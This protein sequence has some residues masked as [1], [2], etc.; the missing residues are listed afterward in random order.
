VSARAPQRSPA[1]GRR[2]WACW[3]CSPDATADL[4]CARRGPRRLGQPPTAPGSDFI[5]LK[6]GKLTRARNRPQV[7]GHKPTVVQLPARGRRSN[8]LEVLRRT[9]WPST[10]CGLSTGRS[11]CRGSQSLSFP[12]K[13]DFGPYKSNSPPPP[14]G[15]RPRRSRPGSTSRATASHDATATWRRRLTTRVRVDRRGRTGLKI[16]GQPLRPVAP[17]STIF[18][19][20]VP[21]QPAQGNVS[22]T[23]NTPLQVR[24]RPPVGP[25]YLHGDGRLRTIDLPSRELQDHPATSFGPA[26]CERGAVVLDTSS[27]GP[28]PPTPAASHERERVGAPRPG[29][30]NAANGR[31]SSATA[32]AGEQGFSK[33]GGRGSCRLRPPRRR[34]R[35]GPPPM[36]SLLGRS[37]RRSGPGCSSLK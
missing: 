8:G 21:G 12:G 3:P 9:R 11:T 37:P 7:N 2:P 19:T 35:P 31:C 29:A 5:N 25:A 18:L 16:E 22:I 4:H 17:T 23:G 36:A 24:E 27:T 6:P 10:G 26:D 30:P 34:R 32:R 28:T 33:P 1:V 14:A 15:E 20:P 13:S